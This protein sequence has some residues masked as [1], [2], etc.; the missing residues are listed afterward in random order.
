MS[1]KT[2]IWQLS[3]FGCLEPKKTVNE[4]KAICENEK[5]ES[6]ILPEFQSITSSRFLLSV[7][8]TRSNRLKFRRMIYI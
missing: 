4:F 8:T 1:C 5:G 2:V 7:K 3:Y 6:L